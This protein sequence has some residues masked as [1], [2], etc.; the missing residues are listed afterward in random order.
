MR[1][2]FL[3][4]TDENEA[5]FRDLESKEGKIVREQISNQLVKEYRSII[6]GSRRNFVKE[7]PKW[8]RK[9]KEVCFN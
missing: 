3:R 7:L 2:L 5:T 4:V 8:H 1:Y 9:L 6:H